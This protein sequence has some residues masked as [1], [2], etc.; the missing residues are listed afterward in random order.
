MLR[1]NKLIHNH[2]DLSNVTYT[3]VIT[4]AFAKHSYDIKPKRT[5][6]KCQCLLVASF[7][8]VRMIR[9]QLLA[10]LH[11]W[12]HCPPPVAQPSPVRTLF[13]GA[14]WT[15]S[16]DGIERQVCCERSSQ[17]GSRTLY[18]PG[19]DM[20]EP[21]RYWQSARISTG[22]SPGRP[23]RVQGWPPAVMEGRLPA[24]PAW[25]VGSPACHVP[26]LI[27]NPMLHLI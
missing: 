13:K 19:W 21:L 14:P 3:N 27:R 4:L 11:P 18:V 16:Y 9:L 1:L 6:L 12:R 26:L 22:S 24:R 15:A 8:L 2:L 10:S 25:L 20:T 5:T 23:G 7:Q 17:R